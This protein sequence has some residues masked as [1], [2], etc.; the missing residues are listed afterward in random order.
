MNKP[1]LTH[2][3]QLKKLETEKGLLIPNKEYA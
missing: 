2:E 3:Q 1:F